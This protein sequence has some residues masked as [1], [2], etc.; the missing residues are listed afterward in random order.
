MIITIKHVEVKTKG[1]NEWRTVTDEN[2][3]T[4]N[5]FSQLKDTW[6][7][8]VEG[9]TVELVKRKNEHNPKFWDVVD[10]KPS[11]VKEAVQ[12]DKSSDFATFH[13]R[14]TSI[15]RQNALTNAVNYGIANKMP[16]G[17]VLLTAGVFYD[18]TSSGVIPEPTATQD[19]P[20]E[21]TESITEAQKKKLGAQI[22]ERELKPT[23]IKAYMLMSFGKE[24]SGDLTMG[25][26]SALIT[27][28][29]NGDIATL[30]K[31]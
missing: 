22:R 8:L 6:P 15:E 5:I 1:E 2:D 9:A 11:G 20:P 29:E 7:L 10:V 31:E 18:W 14:Q 17:E 24:H 4:H 19:M 12:Q 28:I 23:Q 3:K 13:M 26:A 27:A 21:A 16:A 30:T 25:E